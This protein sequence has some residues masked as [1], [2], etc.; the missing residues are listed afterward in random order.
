MKSKNIFLSFLFCCMLLLVI[1]QKPKQTAQPKA[2]RPLEIIRLLNDSR[3]APPE[4]G[5]D[6]LIGIA[7]SKKVV[8]DRAWRLSILEEAYRRTADVKYRVRRKLIPFDGV[9]VDT[10]PNYLSYVFDLKLDELSLKGRIIKLIA[11][12]SPERAKQLLFQ[13]G[14]RLELKPL[15]WQQSNYGA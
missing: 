12:Q 13:I 6:A 11:S 1:G 7:D 5:I 15:V 2:E 4:L 10:Q 3:T 9:S 8:N 14:G